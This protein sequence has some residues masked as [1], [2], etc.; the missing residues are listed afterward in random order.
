MKDPEMAASDLVAAI[1]EIRNQAACYNGRS[2]PPIGLSHHITTKASTPAITSQLHPDHGSLSI[3]QN[4]RNHLLGSTNC[5]LLDDAK[6][7]V[8]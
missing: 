1:R 6:L 3:T 8:L 5:N 2:V 7:M 4:Y